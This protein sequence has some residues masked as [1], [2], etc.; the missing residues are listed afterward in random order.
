M[1]D[2]P[3]RIDLA[4]EVQVEMTEILSR[5][6]ANTIDL[7][8]QF[9]CSHWNV[10]GMQFFQLHQLFD[11]LAEQFDDF[12]DFLAE[13]IT[14]LGGRAEG[15]VQ[16][17]VQ[18]SKI[19]PYPANIS[20]GPEHLVALAERIALYGKAIRYGI[21]LADGLGDASSA[22]LYTE[23]SRATDKSLWL[24]EAHLQV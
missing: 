5:S 12:S 21:E 9:K 17:V 15:T 4:P 14:A 3:S 7:R 10:K 2:Y 23:I 24:L 11:T 8:M 6:L 19:S 18:K 20:A 22:D 1:K 13:R 16:I